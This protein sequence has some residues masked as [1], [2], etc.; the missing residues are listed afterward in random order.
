MIYFLFWL[1][2]VLEALGLVGQLF[3]VSKTSNESAKIIGGIIGTLL[4]SATI[5]WLLILIYPVLNLVS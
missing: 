4:R 2:V 1:V 3:R 5:F